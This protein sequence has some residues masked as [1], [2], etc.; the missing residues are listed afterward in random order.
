MSRS[1]GLLFSFTDHV[2]VVWVVIFIHWP[3]P[4]RLGSKLDEQKAKYL[5]SEAKVRSTHNSYL[6][7]LNDANLYQ[8]QYSCVILPA[9]LDA[10]QHFQEDLVKLWSVIWSLYYKMPCYKQCTKFVINIVQN[11]GCCSVIE[12]STLTSHSTHIRDESFQQLIALLLTI[13]VIIHI[14][15]ISRLKCRRKF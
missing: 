5:R 6:I 11:Y 8:R 2:Q 13:V 3:C 7:A 14:L 4:G 10:Q 9:M 12:Q 1:T 15:N